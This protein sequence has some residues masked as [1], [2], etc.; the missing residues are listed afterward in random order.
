M[1]RMVAHVRAE[2]PVREQSAFRR[3]DGTDLFP[4]G[5]FGNPAADYVTSVTTDR[6]RDFGYT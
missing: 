6:L 4:Y 3:G 1:G 2:I 5:N